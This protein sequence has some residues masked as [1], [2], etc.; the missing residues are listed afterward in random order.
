MVCILTRFLCYIGAPLRD[1]VYE[2]LVTQ[3]FYYFPGRAARNAVALLEVALGRHRIARPE[4]AALDP[5]P[6]E[7]GNLLVDRNRVVTIHFT[8]SHVCH[9]R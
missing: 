9:A 6:D 5:A 1:G 8:L 4:F 2:T 3:D 7:P